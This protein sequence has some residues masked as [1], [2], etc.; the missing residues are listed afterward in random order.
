[1]VI[2]FIMMHTFIFHLHK[3]IYFL[4][5]LPLSSVWA[6]LG[7]ISLDSPKRA[8]A[9]K[10]T[11]LPIAFGGIGFIPKTT[12]ILA[13]YIKSYVIVVFIIVKFIVDQCPFFFETLTRVDNNNFHFQQ[14]LKAA[15]NLLSPQHVRVFLLLN[16]PSNNKWFDFRI[17]SHSV[18]IILPFPTCF[19][20]WYLKPIMFKNYHVLALGWVFGV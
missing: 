9:Y 13:T 15:C 2:I 6:P 12:I 3:V 20:T 5:L 11:F 7:P 1:M 8:L 4:W 16:N 19:S 14:H 18:C 10:Q 17:S